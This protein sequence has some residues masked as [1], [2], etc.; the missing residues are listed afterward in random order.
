MPD[1]EQE[2][3]ASEALPGGWQTTVHRVGDNI[4][5]SPSSWSHSVLEL[6]AHL[7]RRGFAGSPRPVGSGFDA[8]GHELLTFVEGESPQPWPWADEAIVRLGELLA[9]MHDAASDHEPADGAVWKDWFGRRLGDPTR[10]FGHGDLGPWNIMALDGIPSG[11]ID[12]DTAGPLDPIFEVAQAAWLNVQLHDDDLAER[13]G[14]ADV[15]KR[16]EQLRL[17]LDAYGLPRADRSGFVDKMVEVAVHDAAHEAIEHEVT[18][19][20]ATGTADNGYPFAWGI[21]WRVRSAG[22]MLRHR[23]TLEAAINRPTL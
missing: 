5:R 16:A 7:E 4:R 10:G 22:W 3:A 17:F 11:F 21:A 12:W 2:R 1:S 20:T 19:E 9:A 14:L 23:R 18:P 6:L 13:L 15:G 8:D